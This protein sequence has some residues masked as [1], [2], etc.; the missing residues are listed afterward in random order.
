MAKITVTADAFVPLGTQA[1]SATVMS[2]SQ[3]CHIIF[4]RVTRA[5]RFPLPHVT[6][7]VK[8]PVGQVDLNRFFLFILYKQI[9][10]FQ[11]SWSRA[12]DDFE[13]RQALVTMSLQLYAIL[14]LP[15][16]SEV[17]GTAQSSSDPFLVDVS[18][19]TAMP[20]CVPDHTI[21]RGDRL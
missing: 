5:R 13:K 21:A 8:L 14:H 17:H 7:Q 12:S 19:R 4:V 1:S 2:S 15:Q 18:W 20:Y 11:N 6:G 9:E 10:G 3:L 16:M